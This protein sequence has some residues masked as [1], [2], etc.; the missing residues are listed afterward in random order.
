MPPVPCFHCGTNFMRISNDPEA[1]RLCNNCMVLEQKRTPKEVIKSDTIGITIQ[2]SR[3]VHAEVEDICV[4]N[5]WTYSDYFSKLHSK[6]NELLIPR[7]VQVEGTFEVIKEYS[8]GD[9]LPSAKNSKDT[10]TKSKKKNLDR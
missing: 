3:G 6:R 7:T 8:E 1:S 2:C 5:G 4:N 10:L 9:K